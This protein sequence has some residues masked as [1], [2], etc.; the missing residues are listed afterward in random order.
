V[1]ISSPCHSRGS[2]NPEYLSAVRLTGPFGGVANDPLRILRQFVGDLF[3]QNVFDGKGDDALAGLL[4]ER[5]Y[6]ADSVG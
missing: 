4:E 3:V 1:A 5:L 6:F 2:G